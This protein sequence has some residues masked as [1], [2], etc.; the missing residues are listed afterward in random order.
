MAHPAPTVASLL[1]EYHPELKSVGG[2]DWGAVHRLDR[3]TSGLVVFARN[4]KTYRY[5]RELFSKNLVEREYIA[6]VE[7]KVAKKGKI[8]WPIGPDPKSSKKVKV[9]KNIKEARSHKA[10]EAITIYEPL[11][12]NLLKIL[13]KTGVRHQIRAHLAAIGHRVIRLHAS[14]LKFRHP[15]GD[16]W[17]EAASPSP[18]SFSS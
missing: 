6:L 14:R 10:Q 18:A 5:F 9:Y 4:E 12:P 2:S 13:I 16:Q 15:Q 1:A 8:D 3:E 7:G 11:T 17:V